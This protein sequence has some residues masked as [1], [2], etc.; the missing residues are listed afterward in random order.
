SELEAQWATTLL[1]LLVPTAQTVSKDLQAYFAL[2]ATGLP[3]DLLLY[4]LIY[5]LPQEACAVFATHLDSLSLD[6]QW[7]QAYEASV[8]LSTSPIFSTNMSDSAP[9]SLEN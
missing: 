7:L 8:W 3:A 6:S 2:L 5:E 4:P 1:P 9:L